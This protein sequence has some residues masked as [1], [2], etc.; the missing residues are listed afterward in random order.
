MWVWRESISSPV[1]LSACGHHCHTS[2]IEQT[3]LFPT[4]YSWLLCH[5]LTDGIC[6]GLFLGDLFC[7]SDICIFLCQNHTI[8]LQF[9]DAILCQETWFLQVLIFVQDCFGYLESFVVISGNMIPPAFNFFPGL[10][11]LFGVFCDSTE[12]FFLSFVLLGQHPLHMEVPRL[13]V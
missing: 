13:G 6:M 4:V 8:L 11:W 7:F 2:F 9:C 1:L 5:R 10:L 3:I 12:I